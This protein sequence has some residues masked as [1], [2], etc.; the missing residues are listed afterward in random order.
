MKIRLLIIIGIV[1]F[2]IVVSI[3]TPF[4]IGGSMGDGIEPATDISLLEKT[5]CIIRDNTFWN[6]T[7]KICEF[8][9]R[10]D[11]LTRDGVVI[12]P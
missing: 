9:L 7:S 2:V 6:D 10:G 5:E 8:D 3:T 11:I 1:I 4:I 12:A